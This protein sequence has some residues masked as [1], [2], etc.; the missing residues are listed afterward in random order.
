MGLLPTASGTAKYFST[1]RVTAGYDAA[2][3]P[4]ELYKQAHQQAAARFLS[5]Y[6]KSTC[7]VVE[8]IKYK[9]G[10]LSCIF[11][12]SGLAEE[13]ANSRAILV[14]SFDGICTRT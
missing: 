12:G 9:G 14:S 8:P 7:W 10:L 3:M 6:V 1:L 4:P 5:L 11:K 2:N 13:V